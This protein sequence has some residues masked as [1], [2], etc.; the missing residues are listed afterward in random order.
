[1]WFVIARHTVLYGF[2]LR[3]YGRTG[4]VLDFLKKTIVVTGHYGTGKTNL[5]VNLAV[6]LQKQRKQVVLVDL[7]IVN[8]YFRT[9]DF[10]S[11]AR[12]RGFELYAP[13]YANSNVD[14]PMVTAELGAR[15]GGEAT[16]IVDVGGDDSGAM[17]L[18]GYASRIAQTPYTMLYVINR[19]RTMIGAPEDA[20]ALMK[21]IEAASRLTVTH[22]VNN[23]H[24]AGLTRRE[25]L[26]SSRDYARQVS[27]IT[28]KPLAFTAVRRDMADNLGMQDIYPVDIHV[29]TPWQ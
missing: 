25:D 14:L 28:G 23:S 7:D 4:A 24:L 26:E 12:K 1:V 5:S 18:G 11:F 3:I 19:F 17:A 13:P 8:P 15:L 10:K 16:V 2:K 6:D 22:L 20:A 9:A 29:K 27:R 21:Q